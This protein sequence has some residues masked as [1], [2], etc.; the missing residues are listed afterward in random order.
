MQPRCPKC[1]SYRMMIVNGTERQSL[2]QW[3]GDSTQTT[4][5]DSISCEECGF[6]AS[7]GDPT[8]APHVPNPLR[9]TVEWLPRG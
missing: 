9:E 5:D 6:E 1:G 3:R 4:S 8:Q 2:A 7:V